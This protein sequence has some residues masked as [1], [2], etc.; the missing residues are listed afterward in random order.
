MRAITPAYFFD[1]AKGLAFAAQ[2]PDDS[3]D[4]EGS[5]MLFADLAKNYDVRAGL[6]TLDRPTLIVHGHQDPMGDKTAEDLH[7]LIKSSTLVYLDKCGHFPWP[8][9]PDAFRKAISG[10][11][12]ELATEADIRRVSNRYRLSGRLQ[13][14]EQ[15]RDQLRHRRVDGHRAL[16]HVVR[17]RRR[18]SCRARRGSPRRRRCRG[19]RRRES[20]ASPHRRRPS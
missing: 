3:L 19:S 6:R 1:R 15:R 2:M 4:G 18:S 5:A 10:F 9:Q 17:R 12:A 11:L 14:A 16:Q 7:A 8:E 13:V 20:S